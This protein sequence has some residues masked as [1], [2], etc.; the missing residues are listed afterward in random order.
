MQSDSPPPSLN[1]RLVSIGISE[2]H[3]SLIANRKR[4]P[5]LGLAL[6]IE[7]KLGIPP[8]FWVPEPASVPEDI[9]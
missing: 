9:Q 3:A 1:A 7:R 6:R 5:S 2:S 8:S 4:L